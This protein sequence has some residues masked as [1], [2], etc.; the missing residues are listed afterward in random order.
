MSI[1]D[2]IPDPVADVAADAYTQSALVGVE[3]WRAVAQPTRSRWGSGYT[4]G[5][6]RTEGS[7]GPFDFD[8]S[9]PAA[10]SVSGLLPA[11]PTAREPAAGAPS[12]LRSA[13]VTPTSGVLDSA[14]SFVDTLGQRALP[15]V[16]EANRHAEELRRLE[17]QREYLAR[18]PAT[19]ATAGSLPGL[20][21]PSIGGS[22]G[23]LGAYVPAL[24]VLVVVIFLLRALTK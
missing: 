20:S 10:P 9:A 14:L 16:S 17:L 4:Q 24:V 19:A 22:L 23:N 1:L 2:A 8:L 7:T 11:P 15:Y 13:T 6:F 18:V 12:L 21:W 5:W 3:A